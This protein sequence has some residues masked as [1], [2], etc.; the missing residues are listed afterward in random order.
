MAK[1]RDSRTAPTKITQ[2]KEEHLES[3]AQKEG[4]ECRGN[5]V[6]LEAPEDKACREGR[7]SQESLGKLADL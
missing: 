1:V 4:E 7:G 3:V 5:L 6:P 2:G